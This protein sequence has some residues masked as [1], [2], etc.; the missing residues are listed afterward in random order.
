MVDTIYNPFTFNH[1]GFYQ[2]DED[3]DYLIAVAQW[4]KENGLVDEQYQNAPE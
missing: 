1:F 2:D 3:P 4:Q